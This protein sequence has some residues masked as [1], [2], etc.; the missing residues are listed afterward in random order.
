MVAREAIGLESVTF[1]IGDFVLQDLSLSIREGEYFVLTGPNGSG[2]SITIKLIAGLLRP[3]AGEVR[4]DTQPVTQVPPWKRNIGYV[5][6]DGVLFPNRT[7]RENIRFGLEIRRADAET[8][9]RE[10]ARVVA[11]MGIGHLAD[12]M[13]QGLSGGER[14]KAS[15]ARALAF[16]PSVLLLDEPVSAI[17]EEARDALC[18]DLR[19]IQRELSITTL[20]ISHNRQE[21]EFVADR[22][23]VLSAG[24]LQGIKERRPRPEVN[25]EK[26]S[27]NPR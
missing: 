6:Q 11:M 16:R 4:I 21:T 2:K 12:R 20:H 13:P 1:R 14:Q 8:L 9:R 17:D 23:G 3:E 22:V 19:R 24:K 15:L 27:D 26:Q 10:V 5:P 25:R 7:V 18:Q